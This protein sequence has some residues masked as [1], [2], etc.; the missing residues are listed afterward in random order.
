MKILDPSNYYINEVSFDKVTRYE[1]EI[2]SKL[3]Y[4]VHFQNTLYYQM[5]QQGPLSKELNDLLYASLFASY[6]EEFHSI[7][8]VMEALLSGK[9]NQNK[10][11]K[12]LKKIVAKNESFLKQESNEP[13]K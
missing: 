4:K 13:N 6:P 2:L 12:D 10:Y 9:Q 11:Y 1:Q 7:K 8:Q 5:H 3:D